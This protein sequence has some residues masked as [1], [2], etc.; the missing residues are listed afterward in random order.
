MKKLLIL[1]FLLLAIDTNAQNFPKNPNKIDKNNLKQGMWTTFHYNDYDPASNKEFADLYAV[2][3]MIDDKQTGSWT[4]FSMETNVKVA[5]RTF[6]NERLNGIATVY[7][8]D[9][10]AISQGNYVNGL[11]E[12]GWYTYY[13]NG[14]VYLE[15]MYKDDERI[16]IAK[17]YDPT[18]KF[19]NEAEYEKEKP[20]K[21][22]PEKVKTPKELY[23]EGETYIK[24]GY[25]AKAVVIFE[26]TR[27]IVEKEL[28]KKNKFYVKILDKLSI[29]YYVEGQFDK[30]KEV[31]ME[32]LAIQESL[33]G[34]DNIEYANL[35]YSLFD[36]QF[37]LKD[38]ANAEQTG[39][40]LL[41]IYK[42]FSGKKSDNYIVLEK[43][44]TFIREKMSKKK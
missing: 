38:F 21:A 1:V 31:A 22:P 32:G 2:G 43:N 26:K 34:I 23:E 13:P 3:E 16:G 19:I 7:Q 15:I 4:Y 20:K 14:Q 44:I 37:Y 24:T 33:A 27:I 6:K 29:A 8:N 17:E 28:G 41:A 36:V 35:L 39:T 12:G 30:V 40:K 11:R 18:G 10:K 5:V 25:T 9:G 42:K